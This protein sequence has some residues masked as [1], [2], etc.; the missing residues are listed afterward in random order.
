MANRFSISSTHGTLAAYSLIAGALA[1]PSFAQ[2]T[3]FPGQ[4]SYATGNGPFGCAL[5]DIAGSP[6]LDMVVANFAG[7]KVSL[8]EGVGDG[9]FVALGLVTVGNNPRS[10]VVGDFNADGKPDLATANASDD[11]IAV[12]LGQGSFAF[13]APTTIPVS[14]FP[15]WVQAGDLNGDNKL[16]LVCGT[17]AGADISVSLG[18]GLGGFGGAVSYPVTWEVEQIRLGDLNGDGFLDVVAT[19]WLDHRLISMLGNGQGAFGAPIFNYFGGAPKG[20]ALSD[21]DADG[22]LEAIVADTQNHAVLVLKGNGNG[23]FQF[24]KFH[25]LS[26]GPQDLAVADFTGDGRPDIV[27]ADSAVLSKLSVLV[28]VGGGD[29]DLAYSSP[30][31]QSPTSLAVGKLNA[32]NQSDVVVTYYGYDTVRSHLTTLSFGGWERYCLAKLNSAGCSPLITGEGTP[33][34]SNVRPFRVRTLLALSPSTGLYLYGVSGSRAAIPFQ[35]GTLCL[36]PAG[37]RR[38]PGLPAGGQLGYDCSGVFDLDFNA[39]AAGLLGGTPSPGLLIPGVHYLVQSWSRD[40]FS[41][42]FPVG[43]SDA[44]E[45]EV[46]P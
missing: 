2:G 21:V 3:L 43:L 13:A 27:S 31:A 23:T 38:T 35:G 46:G 14:D 8:Y 25:P 39:F 10:V 32:D 41:T 12:L 5:A 6:A 19:S 40:V 30:L 28:N 37:I 20:L 22:R 17:Q 15:V 24:P 9:S 26:T 36:G 1:A 7:T 42:P 33:S 45:V 11:T 44:L 16:D 29:F 18:D 34:A 4:S